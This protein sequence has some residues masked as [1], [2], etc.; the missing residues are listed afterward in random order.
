MSEKLNRF[1]FGRRLIPAKWLPIL[2]AILVAPTVS[3]IFKS[4]ALICIA[5]ESAAKARPS[6]P[7]HEHTK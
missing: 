1:R 2:V 4:A 7:Y 6:R 5:A 3:A